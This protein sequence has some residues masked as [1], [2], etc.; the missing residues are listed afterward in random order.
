MKWMAEDFMVNNTD[1]ESERNDNSND[2]SISNVSEWH[3]NVTEL[4][5]HK[6]NLSKTA[7]Y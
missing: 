3:K 7:Y 4:L 1:N 6:H 5:I 2:S